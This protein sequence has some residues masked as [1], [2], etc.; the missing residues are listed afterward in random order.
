MSHPSQGNSWL[1]RPKK[2]GGQGYPE[3]KPNHG[4]SL[5]W[6]GDQ[7]MSVYPQSSQSL[8]QKNHVPGSPRKQGLPVTAGLFHPQYLPRTRS[9]W[10]QLMKPSSKQADER[11]CSKCAEKGKDE[12]RLQVGLRTATSEIRSHSNAPSMGPVV[13][14]GLLMSFIT[15]MTKGFYH[16]H[17]SDHIGQDF[18][19]LW[20]PEDNSNIFRKPPN[21]HMHTCA[22][23]SK[24]IH[25]ELTR[26]HIIEPLQNSEHTFLWSILLTKI[27]KLY[28]CV[29]VCTVWECTPTLLAEEMLYILP[30]RPSLPHRLTLQ[31][32]PTDHWL[33]CVQRGQSLHDPI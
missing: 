13:T 18:W 24:H 33:R 11:E 16:G 17:D 14:G 2:A 31:I 26:S 5:A 7:L 8:H 22:C 12:P 10:S 29:C 1:I 32:P 27:V 6:P 23:A 19:K 20:R 9:S 21:T 4:M 15:S 30:N 25:S 3:K 28:V